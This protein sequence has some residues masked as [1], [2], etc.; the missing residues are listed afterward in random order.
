M[1][2][3]RLGVMILSLVFSLD[4]AGDQTYQLDSAHT[5]IGFIATHMVI[6][7]VRGKFTEN[8]G[9]VTLDQKNRLMDA[10]ATIKTASI[11]TQIESRDD[12]LRSEDF[13]AVEVFP[14]IKF[15]STKIRRRFGKQLLVGELTIKNITRPI[16]LE[17]DLKG[18]IIDPW[19]NSRIGFEASGKI[20]RFDYGLMWNELM[21]GGGLMVGEVIEII[22]NF[23]AVN[24]Q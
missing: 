3:P 20:N 14:E 5:D 10:Q 16:I 7:K 8:S 1:N 11:D 6:N 21:E 2:S 19:G 9:S 22:I 12:H 23:E 13:F 4:V 15:K 24:L 17:Y 18:P